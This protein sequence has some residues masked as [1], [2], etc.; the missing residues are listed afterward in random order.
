M[1]NGITI[2]LDKPRTLRYGMNALAKI[3]DLTGK[4]ILSLDLNKLGIKDLLAIVY[5]G[6]YHED[7]TLT[8]QK[9]GDLIDE[10]S[11]LNEVAEKLGEAL[12]AAFGG[13][14]TEQTPG[15]K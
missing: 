12:T 14:N 3:E 10:Y 2:N 13:E 8:I 9:V 6:L 7:K 11:N 5:G 15:E 4:S 1:K